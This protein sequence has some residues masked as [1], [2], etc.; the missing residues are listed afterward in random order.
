MG[1]LSLLDVAP[2]LDPAAYERFKRSCK[3]LAADERSFS[4]AAVRVDFA[5]TQDPLHAGLA[6]LTDAA[7]AAPAPFGLAGRKDET[8]GSLLVGLAFHEAYHAG[9]VGMLRRLLGKPGAIV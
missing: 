9:Q 6:D 5:A 3:A 7:V 4:L 1:I 2:P 8:V